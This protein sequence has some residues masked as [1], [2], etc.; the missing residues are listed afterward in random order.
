MLQV[1][2]AGTFSA[3]LEPSVRARL[4]T[5]CDVIVGDEIGIVPRL[6]EVD[7]LVTLAFNREMA[8]RKKLSWSR[9]PAP[10][11]IGSTARR[12]PRRRRSPTPTAMKSAS[13]S[14]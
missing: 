13:P 8:R 12:C 1:A 5:P 11:S 2:F 4:H 6:T 3:T 7:V 9:R 10:G 14:T